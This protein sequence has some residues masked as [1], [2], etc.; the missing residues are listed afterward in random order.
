[1]EEM[2]RNEKEVDMA[3]EPSY[4][5]STD[6][7]MDNGMIVR[8]HDTSSA[9]WIELRTPSRGGEQG[10]VIGT[11]S[12]LQNPRNAP[13]AQVARRVFTFELAKQLQPSSMEALA[14]IR[15]TVDL[16]IGGRS[17]SEGTQPKA[18][19]PYPYPIASMPAQTSARRS[20][21][22]SKSS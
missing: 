22:G 1:M 13:E 11:I 16:G 18:R 21:S 8:L 7:M 4:L 12:R 15:D 17:I 3:R 6:Y 9:M 19:A 20:G 10:A 5:G 2:T 14:A